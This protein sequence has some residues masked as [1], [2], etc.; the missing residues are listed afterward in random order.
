MILVLPSTLILMM[1]LEVYMRH[2]FAGLTAK[3]FEYPGHLNVT[4]EL[5]T[6]YDPITDNEIDELGHILE[7]IYSFDQ[8]IK[9]H[10]QTDADNNL[11]ASCWAEGIKEQF[12]QIEVLKSFCGDQLNSLQQDLR[13]TNNGNQQQI[14]QLNRLIS[15]YSNKIQIYTQIRPELNHYLKQIYTWL[16]SQDLAQLREDSTCS[17]IIGRLGEPIFKCPEGFHESAQQAVNFLTETTTLIDVLCQVRTNIAQIFANTFL[18]KHQ[19]NSNMFG[20]HNHAWLLNQAYHKFQTLPQGQNGARTTNDIP[21]LEEKAIDELYHYFQTTYQYHKL[22]PLILETIQ[23][24][25]ITPKLGETFESLFNNHCYNL[26]THAWFTDKIKTICQTTEDDQSL[27]V[28][29]MLNLDENYIVNGINWAHIGY[30]IWHQLEQKRLLT[31]KLNYSDL[32]YPYQQA[33]TCY[34]LLNLAKI[35]HNCVLQLEQFQDT[36]NQHLTTDDDTDFDTQACQILQQDI[37]QLTA[38]IIQVL[39]TLEKNDQLITIIMQAFNEALLN[40]SAQSIEAVTQ[41]LNQY[42][43][44]IVPIIA[45]SYS[46]NEDSGLID[47]IP[48][49]ARDKLIRTLQANLHTPTFLEWLKG[50]D[51]GL[52]EAKPNPSYQAKNVYFKPL[53]PNTHIYSFPKRLEI[54]RELHPALYIELVD[55]NNHPPQR[56]INIAKGIEL[57][58]SRETDPQSEANAWTLHQVIAQNDAEQALDI[59]KDDAD[60]VLFLEPHHGNSALM[61]AA[62]Q[63]HLDIVETILHYRPET[64]A[65]RNKAGQTALEQAASQKHTTIIKAIVTAYPDAVNL[66]GSEQCY[67]DSELPYKP[68]ARI[69]YDDDYN[70]TYEY[71]Q[72]TQPRAI[73]PNYPKHR[74][75]PLSQCLKLFVDDPSLLDLMLN[76]GANP[77]L[78]NDATTL[79]LH[80]ACLAGLTDAVKLLIQKG[81]T[82]D[83]SIDSGFTPLQLAASLGFND[84]ISVLLDYGANI[85]HPHTQPPLEIAAKNEDINTIQQLISNGADIQLVNTNSTR[86]SKVYLTLINNK[87][88][89]TGKL[90]LFSAI[91]NNEFFRAKS[92]LEGGALVNLVNDDQQTPL[93][94]A[95]AQRYQPETSTKTNRRIIQL[96]IEYNASTAPIFNSSTIN[97]IVQKDTDL[98][99]L[100]QVNNPQTDG[101]TDLIRQIEDSDDSETVKNLIDGGAL[102]NKPD[103]N[104]RTPLHYAALHGRISIINTLIKNGANI[105]AKDRHLNLPIHLAAAFS[106]YDTVTK[107]LRKMH[108]KSVYNYATARNDQQDTPIDLAIQNNNIET[109][110][111]LANIKAFNND[112]KKSQHPS[113]IHKA[114]CRQNGNTLPTLINYHAL[115]DIQD[116]LKAAIL[117][118]S[119]CIELLLNNDA[120]LTVKSYADQQNALHIAAKFGCQ[121]AL[122]ILLKHTHDINACDHYGH[123]PLHLAL[124]YGQFSCAHLL[125]D[126]DAKLDTQNILGDTLLHTAIRHHHTELVSKLIH[127]GIDINLKN[128]DNLTPLNEASKWRYFDIINLLLNQPNINI[129]C[130]KSYSQANTEWFETV[131][132]KYNLATEDIAAASRATVEKLGQPPLLTAILIGNFEM[133]QAFLDEQAYINITNDNNQNPLHMAINS[134]IEQHVQRPSN[135]SPDHNYLRQIFNKS[136][137]IDTT[138][139]LSLENH[140][141]IINLLIRY[142]T[143]VNAQDDKGN[144]PLHDAIYA[145]NISIIQTL[146]N[147]NADLTIENHQGYMPTQFIKGENYTLDAINNLINYLKTIDS[148]PPTYIRN[149]LVASF[150]KNITQAEIDRIA[151]TENKSTNDVLKIEKLAKLK[152]NKSPL[153]HLINQDIDYY[154]PNDNAPI[155]F[156]DMFRHL[157]Q[158]IISKGSQKLNTDDPLSSFAHALKKHRNCLTAIFTQA[159]TWQHVTQKLNMFSCINN[160]DQ[161]KPSKQNQTQKDFAED[162]TQQFSVN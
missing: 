150:D 36:N 136:R 83:A 80:E 72:L 139:P 47:N 61:L 55:K 156:N 51:P 13:N 112:P 43:T 88:E 120:S 118:N 26:H 159:K 147:N 21:R 79:P 140:L 71:P 145:S 78:T 82:I 27:T 9:E 6:N 113:T 102:V 138:R 94:C 149:C 162:K 141:D 52:V 116:H 32:Q 110:Q 161:H 64:A 73:S 1:N 135:L 65:F 53:A 14:E 23:S 104:D 30:I 98:H 4:N 128:N 132:I 66:L 155:R 16:A 152:G 108:N 45:R 99:T 12:T 87:P 81:A 154:I 57:Y 158:Q 62:Q 31:T 115:A 68:P 90:P 39:N 85:D 7:A 95:I 18:N 105:I 8:V 54:L 63:G 75:R 97:D 2:Q 49:A 137:Q 106:R 5:Q 84:I 134:L 46:I 100:L 44:D 77:N 24:T 146:I 114:I 103:N 56:Y 131:I 29:T 60:T 133:I 89:Q 28:H 37:S 123:T 22:V 40:D 10:T 67:N 15:L 38:T 11:R 58:T 151:S 42:N 41:A 25:I 33:K 117:W 70:T 160:S 109:I 157:A 122:S 107:L 59:I 144:T 142:G 143:N 130:S 50:D 125:I 35:R 121:R 91:E 129:N 69:I 86:T 101:K 153:R 74:M 3:A 48:C 96:L 148:L 17:Q 93:E 127:L 34:Y 124:Q 126:N 76:Q 20:V 19:L 119:D 111:C 92:L